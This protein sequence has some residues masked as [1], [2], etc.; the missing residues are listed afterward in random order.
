MAEGVLIAIGLRDSMKIELRLPAELNGSESGLSECCGCHP[1]YPSG[2]SS[3]EETGDSPQL[4][5]RLLE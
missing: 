1:F 5:T 4:P 3:R 2:C